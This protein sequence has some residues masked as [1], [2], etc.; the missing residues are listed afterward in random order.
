MEADGART[1]K[2]R[3]RTTSLDLGSLEP[4]PQILYPKERTE[5]VTSTEGYRVDEGYS[6][7]PR[8]KTSTVRRSSLPM[9][10]TSEGMQRSSSVPSRATRQLSPL[11]TRK[12]TPEPETKPKKQGIFIQFKQKRWPILVV[13]GMVSALLLWFVG[14]AVLNWGTDR[15]NDFRYGNPRT[16]QTD[17]AV[18][19]GGDSSAHPSHFIAMNF[20]NQAVVIEFK[21]GKVDKG[22]V[23]WYVA[24]IIVNDGEAPVTVSFR[25]VNNDQKLDMIVDVHLPGQDQISI[26]INDGDNF[27]IAI[28]SDN[29]QL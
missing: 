25:D 29:V 23:V 16:F 18:G 10:P 9:G 6:D 26:F 22:S 1:S 5:R 3:R 2:R 7:P 17:M 19:H 4:K 13:L 21:A 24:P 28:P 20:N 27:R 11:T 15:Y 8:P 12:I 14:R